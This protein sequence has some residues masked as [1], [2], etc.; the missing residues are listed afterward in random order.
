VQPQTVDLV[1]GYEVLLTRRQLDKPVDSTSG[2]PTRLM[3]NL[4]AIF[5][6]PDVLGKSS[7]K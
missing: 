1:N 7:G 5:F 2:I 6:S 4:L 3:R